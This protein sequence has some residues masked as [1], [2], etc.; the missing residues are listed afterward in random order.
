MAPGTSISGLEFSPDRKW[1]AF[2]H[3]TFEASSLPTRIRILNVDTGET[4]VLLEPVSGSANSNL[5][6][7]PSGDLLVQRPTGTGAS[8]ETVLVPVEGGA[9]RPFEFPGIAAVATRETPS[10][11]LVAKWSPDGRTLVISRTSQGG[12][13]FV[14]ENPLAAVSPTTASR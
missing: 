2:R 1:L 11:G 10:R 4:R 13:T 7:T 5:S 8:M 12:E 6:W 3:V 14:I 9:P